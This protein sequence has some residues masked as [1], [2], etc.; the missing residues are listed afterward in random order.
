MKLSNPFYISSRLQSAVKI[1]NTE[2]SLGFSSRPGD[3]GRDRYEYSIEGLIDAAD[4]MQS[5]CQGGSILA[6]W[7]SLLSFLSHGAEQYRYHGMGDREQYEAADPSWP[8]EV[9][10]WAYQH[11]NEI[12]GLSLDLEEDGESLIDERDE[13]DRESGIS[14]E[15]REGY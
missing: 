2:V 14:A 9:A 7:Q 8:I 3:D 10:E 4:D 15:F 5:G 1:G 12:E 11:E 13:C 6:G